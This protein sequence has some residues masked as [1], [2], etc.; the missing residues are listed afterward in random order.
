MNIQTV[1]G[2]SGVPCILMVLAL[3][4]GTV[5]PG[6]DYVRAGAMVKARTGS[7]TVYNPEL[8]ATIKEKVGQ[9]LDHGLTAQ[10]AVRVALLNNRDFQSQFQDIGVSRAEVVQSSLLT[11]PAISLGAR[12]PEGGGRSN[13]TFGLGQELVDLWQI[14]VRKRIAKARLDQAVMNVVQSAVELA[15]RVKNAYYR[16]RVSQESTVAAQEN[17]D[18]LRRMAQMAERR[19]NAGESTILD[20]NLVKSNILDATIRLNSARRD[21]EVDRV[22]FERLLGL[23]MDEAGVVRLTDPLTEQAEAVGDDKSLVEIALKS[24]LDVRTASLDIDAAAE[25]IKRQKRAIVPSL[26]LGIEAE[27]TERR[28]PRSLKPLPTDLPLPSPSQTLQDF[29]TQQVEQ[30]TAKDFILQRYDAH[31][32]RELEKR[33]NIDLL[34]GPSV[35]FTLPVWDQNKAQIAKARYEFAKKQKQYEELLLAV[36]QEV[37]Q[38]AATARSSAELLRLSAQEAVPLAEKNVGT[39]QR[40]YEAGEDTILALLLAQQT[41][42]EQRVSRIK[43]AGDYATALAELEQ[44]LGGTLNDMPRE[45]TANMP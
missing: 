19:F 17:V 38:A 29:V 30:G 2:K 45:G 7:D 16:L 11:N 4:C 9:F 24:R 40:L 15:A 23:S 26:S 22:A 14:P 36:V 25:E 8:E 33:Q 18:L 42:N 39:A 6:A 37:R 35:Q 27:R 44:A 12:F 20:L 21:E 43:F 32:E 1:L 28:A 13:L 3:G 34:L 41:L 5:R 10:E 31:R